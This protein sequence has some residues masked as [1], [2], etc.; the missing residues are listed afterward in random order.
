MFVDTPLPD[1]LQRKPTLA[2]YRRAFL[3]AAEWSLRH[4]C[5]LPCPADLARRKRD[6]RA[7]GMR[8]TFSSYLIANIR[9]QR[10]LDV[11]A[12]ITELDESEVS[13]T[14]ITV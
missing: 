9:A 8:T 1:F 11:R 10:F 12:G 13:Q 14:S 6:A 2:D 3:K 5:R 4:G 7:A